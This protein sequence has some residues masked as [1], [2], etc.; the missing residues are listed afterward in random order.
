MDWKIWEL[1][2]SGD[3]LNYNIIKMGQNKVKTLG[4]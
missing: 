2:E 1:E 3:H 4:D